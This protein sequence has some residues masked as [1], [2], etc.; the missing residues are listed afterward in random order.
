MEQQENLEQ[1]PQSVQEPTISD[2]QTDN[3][4]PPPEVD[5]LNNQTQ[6]DPVT[7]QTIPGSDLDSSKFYTPDEFYKAFKSVFQ[8]GGDRL[9]IESLPIKPSEEVG[10]RITSDRIYEMAEKY[11][12]LRFIIDKRS[13][14]VG[15]TILMI[16]FLAFKAG[17]VYRE[18][19]KSNLG[20]MIW[21][22]T[23]G[24]F[25]RHRQTTGIDMAYSAPV[26]PEKQQKQE[27][28]SGTVSA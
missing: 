14:R 1:L 7:G 11:A 25:N 8:F 27:N 4:P 18:K 22:K 23:K 16:Q 21:K 15:E 24:L 2:G 3:L 13:T 17:D 19:T 26:E 20:S 28:L 9:G 12:F 10:A 5:S 6:P